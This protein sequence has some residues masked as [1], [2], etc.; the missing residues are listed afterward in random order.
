VT[1]RQRVLR[2]VTELRNVRSQY[3]QKALT[4]G[5]TDHFDRIF[6]LRPSTVT[7]DLDLHIVKMN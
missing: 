5:R 3:D 6:L 2:Y 4:R 1:S 7:Y